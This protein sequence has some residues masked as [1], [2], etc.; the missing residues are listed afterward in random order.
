MTVTIDHIGIAVDSLEDRLPFW[1][2]ALGLP[3]GGTETVETEGVRVVFLN[4]GDSRIELLEPTRED[5]AIAKFLAK[6]GEGINHVT[7]AVPDIEA[8]LGRLRERGI[9]AI[10][11]APRAGAGGTRVAFLHPRSCGGVLMELVERRSSARVDDIAPGRAVLV[12]LREP[13]EKMWGVL[14]RLDP[15]GLVFEG[16]DLTSF[17][18]WASQVER[19]DDQVVGP[20]TL[21]VPMARVERVLL[22]RPSGS[23][24]SLAERFRDRTGRSVQDV[25]GW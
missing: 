19:E 7:L 16:I 10:G 22:D 9:T 25:L 2:D 24:P 12:Y 5:S 11:D 8:A 1:R 4:A 6:R 17:D 13:Q 15:T 3:V 14:R 21:F 20:S 18:D 23:L